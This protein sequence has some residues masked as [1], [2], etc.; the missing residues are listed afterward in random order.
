MLALLLATATASAYDVDVVLE[1]QGADPVELHL[2]DVEPGPLPTVLVDGD[3]GAHIFQIDLSI[4]GADQVRLT[5]TIDK[6]TAGPRGRLTR[7]TVSQPRV[8]TL[9]GKSAEVSMSHRLPDADE[10]TVQLSAEFLVRD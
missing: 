5:V 9:L 3:A 8:T 2:V 7:T 10:D 1:A 4:V 6:L